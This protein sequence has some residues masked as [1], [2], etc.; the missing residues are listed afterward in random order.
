MSVAEAASALGMQA[1]HVSNVEAGRTSLSPERLAI[2]A[3]AASGTSATYIE[4]L[5]EMGQESGKG[6]WSEYRSDLRLPY[7]DVAELEAS[8]VTLTNYEPMFVPGL[9][10]TR[11]Y[12]AAIHRGGYA[13][14]PEEREGVA[15]DFRM[16]RQKILTGERPPHLHAI[17]HEAA[18]HASF[19]SR[20]IMR[21]QLQRLI[22]ASRMSNVTVQVLPFD[23]PVPFGTSFT[24]AEP[25]E[26]ELGTVVVAHVDGSRY[27]GDLDSLA[28]YSH[29]F[30][31]LCEVALPP[32]D[33]E[34]RPESHATRDSLG[35][36]Q[37]LLYPLL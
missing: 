15:V 34:V 9:L 5:A 29:T 33:A 4:A 21:G 37:R 28:W 22:E 20:E 36:I 31:R 32:V 25:P 12:A 30:D 1:P 16:R 24:L 8:A 14:S 7:L 19:G 26:P 6:W 2:L 35:L 3:R 11:E 13:R 10:Q 17:V 23:G 18:L 27:L